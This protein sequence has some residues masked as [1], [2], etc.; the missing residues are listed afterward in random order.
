M[1][2]F[3]NIYND[4]NLVVNDVLIFDNKYVKVIVTMKDNEVKKI[5]IN[6]STYMNLL[7]SEINDYVITLEYNK[8]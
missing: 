7:N 5:N 6:I 8:T 2:Q 1:T 3:I 4:N